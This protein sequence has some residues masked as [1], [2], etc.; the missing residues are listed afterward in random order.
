MGNS[1][2]D[3]DGDDGSVYPKEAAQ[4]KMKMKSKGKSVTEGY[5]FKKSQTAFVVTPVQSMQIDL[6]LELKDLHL[7]FTKV[8]E[9]LKMYLPSAYFDETSDKAQ[10]PVDTGTPMPTTPDAAILADYHS[11]ILRARSLLSRMNRL[12]EN[13][14]N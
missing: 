12:L 10:A 9:S 13:I 8:E 1:G 3:G 11:Q 14:V 6:K 4:S 5:S 2:Y 7:A